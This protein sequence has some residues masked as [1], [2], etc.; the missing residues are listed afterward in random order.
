[1]YNKKMLLLTA[2][3][4]I[5]AVTAGSYY[6]NHIHNQKKIHQTGVMH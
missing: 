3:V 5:I 2:A 4:I 1:M 6:K